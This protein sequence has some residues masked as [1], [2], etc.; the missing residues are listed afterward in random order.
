V[1]YV[2]NGFEENPSILLEKKYFFINPKAGFSYH[3]NQWLAYASWSRGTKEPN[4][5]DFETGIN[6][7][8]VPER[9]DDFEAG[10]ESRK[11]R[12]TWSINFYYMYYHNQLVLTGKINDVGAYTRTNIPES[13]R[14]GTEGQFSATLNKWLSASANITISRNKISGFTEYIDDY[15]NGGQKTKQYGTTDISFSPS[16]I[17]AAGITIT[18]LRSF[19]I[20]ISG[21]Y[22]GRQ[23]LDNTSDDSRKLDAWFTQDARLVYT[24]SGKHLKNVEVICQA[25][26][27]SNAMYEPNGYTFSYFNNNQ[28]TTSNYYFPMAGRNYM[29]GVNVKF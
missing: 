13:Y 11:N 24:Y 20:V 5:D 1:F 25:F 15:D 22:V 16:V 14:L 23:Y 3:K 6:Q 28:L 29:I 21:K 10:V 26:N 18:P 8:P 2:I 4:R 27:L 7:V 9:V 17:S 19:Q 12:F